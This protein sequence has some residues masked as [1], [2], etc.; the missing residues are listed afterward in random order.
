M[1]EKRDIFWLCVAFALSAVAILIMNSLEIPHEDYFFRA[2]ITGLA[3]IAIF[4]AAFYIIKNKTLRFALLAW[5]ATVLIWRIANTAGT[6]E[7]PLAASLFYFAFYAFIFISMHKEI[8]KKNFGNLI[9][10]SILMLVI[11]Y[12]GF[13][14]RQTFSINYAFGIFDALV[15]AMSFIL[16]MQKKPA[17]GYFMLAIADLTLLWQIRGQ[18]Y[19]VASW[20]EIIFVIAFFILAGEKLQKKS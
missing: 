4:S 13:I 15:I 12:F 3:Q 11:I 10:F 7:R 17:F 18:G 6:L 20:V 5:L 1:K 8:D 16:M 19:Y 2:V 9:F 14:F